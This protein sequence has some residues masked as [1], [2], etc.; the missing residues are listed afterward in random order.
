MRL[1]ILVLVPSQ[2]ARDALGEAVVLGAEVAN[3]P[4]TRQLSA[5]DC[6]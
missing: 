3:V 4:Q 6:I 1:Q 5:S 2:Q